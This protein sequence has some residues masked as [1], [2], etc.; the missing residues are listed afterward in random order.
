MSNKMNIFFLLNR[1]ENSSTVTRTAVGVNMK[2]LGVKNIVT[3][4]R[5]QKRLG[6]EFVERKQVE[7]N[8]LNFQL[9]SLLF[10]LLLCIIVIT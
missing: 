9:N 10:T 5:F 1:S 7:T 3:F 2:F 8:C 4:L 6:Y